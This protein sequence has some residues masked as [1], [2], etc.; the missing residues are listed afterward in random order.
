[1]TSSLNED[2]RDFLNEAKQYWLKHFVIN[3]SSYI[4]GYA[5]FVNQPLPKKVQP[6]RAEFL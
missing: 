3:W 5:N 2:V 6:F 4:S 1:M